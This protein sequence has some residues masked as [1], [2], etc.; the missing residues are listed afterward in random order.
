MALSVLP[1]DR[2]LVACGGLT[3]A[4]MTIGHGVDTCRVCWMKHVYPLVNPFYNTPRPMTI[5][6]SDEAVFSSPPRGVSHVG[7]E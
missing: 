1:R 4:L 5:E 7:L 6:W 3:H 2:S